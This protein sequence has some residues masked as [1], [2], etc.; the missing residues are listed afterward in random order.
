MSFNGSG[1]VTTDFEGDGDEIHSVTILNDGKILAGGTT[2]S[3]TSSVTT[4][5]ALVRYNAD[6]SL[7]TS[8]NGTGKV[9]TDLHGGYDYGYGMAVQD[10]GRIVIGG[11]A[12]SNVSNNLDFALVRYNANGSLDT[13]FNGTGKVTT[14]IGTGYDHAFSLAI[15]H[16]GNIVMAG[17]SFNG[18][19]SDFAVVRYEGDA[20]TDGDGIPDLYETGT[21]IYVSPENTGTSPTDP[22]ADDDGLNDGAEVYR[23]HSD[24]FVKDTDGDGFEDGFEATT[25]FSPTS[26]SSTPDAQ[27]SIRTAAE[28]RFNAANGIS[29]RI[30]ASTDLANWQT[31]ETDIIGAGGVITRFYS[32]EGQPKRFFRSR[33]N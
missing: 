24:P 15:Q 33:R 26:P 18:S 3:L 17:N 29:Y 12:H 28:Y 1:K 9:T 21:G 13:T 11:A 14:A 30:E 32:I 4:D 7:D 10:N 20:D 22:D 23:Y 5:I 6:G 2:F 25:G 16:D 19:N 27:S 8:F 31:I